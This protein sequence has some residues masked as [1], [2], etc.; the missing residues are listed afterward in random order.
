MRQAEQRRDRRG[1]KKFFARR[2][3]GYKGAGETIAALMTMHISAVREKQRVGGS[4][5]RIRHNEPSPPSPP[6]LR[7][8]SLLFICISILPARVGA[9]APSR[10]GPLFPSPPVI[11]NTLFKVANA[12]A[13]ALIYIDTRRPCALSADKAGLSLLFARFIAAGRL[14]FHNFSFYLAGLLYFAL[15]F[16][17]AAASS[18]P[19]DA[20]P[21]LRT[22]RFAGK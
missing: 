19:A 16:T 18:F 8:F 10:S 12:L 2:R 5:D 11:G 13:A 3:V 17:V 6:Y 7:L 20:L 15:R 9:S 1:L 4:R 21:S 22:R 14:N